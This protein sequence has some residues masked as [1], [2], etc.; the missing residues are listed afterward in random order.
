[1][2]GVGILQDTRLAVLESIKRARNGAT[3]AA[4]A[5]Q[6]GVS[7]LTIRHHLANLQAEGLVTVEIAR[8][9]VGRPKHIYKVT[10][11][12]QRFFPNKYHLLV[13]GLLDQLKAS[14]PPAQVQL[15]ID[16]MAASVA[17]KY[18]IGKLDGNLTER[19]QRL[20]EILGE[21]G[22]MAE[23][24]QV[25]DAVILTEL[26]CPYL[27]VGQRHPEVCRIDKTLMQNVL[28]Q[29]VE[30]TSCV[31]HGDTCCTFSVKVN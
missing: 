5:E 14:L 19:L 4:L 26:N 8:E 18:N 6:H 10:E 30:Q 29:E 16:G 2:E 28:G 22:F 21:E 27:Y 31:L 24:R 3:I 15:I 7:A 13:E 9:G 12:A 23:V 25:N 17:A 11:A 20:V 1:M